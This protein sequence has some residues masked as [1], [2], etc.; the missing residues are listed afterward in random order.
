MGAVTSDR[1]R[2]AAER[3]QPRRVDRNIKG[4]LKAP[5]AERAERSA[6][7]RAEEGP[8]RPRSLDLSGEADLGDPDRPSDKRRGDPPR[9]F[10]R[11]DRSSDILPPRGLQSAEQTKAQQGRAG[12]LL[13][14][15]KSAG[16]ARGQVDRKARRPGKRFRLADPPT[17]RAL[18]ASKLPRLTRGER[19]GQ[20]AAMP[21][22]SQA[23]Y[24]ALSKG[25]RK[26]VDKL[27][28][29]LAQESGP[30]AEVALIA[31]DSLVAGG[32]LGERDA[33]GRTLLETLADRAGK[34]LV[35]SLARSGVSAAAQLGDIVTA[36]AF[37]GT[38]FQ[39][40]NTA[41]CVAASIE[42]VLS[43]TDPAEYA[44]IAT[45]LL[46]DGVTLLKGGGVVELSSSEAGRDDSGRPLA[47]QLIQGSLRDFAARLPDEAPGEG[48][49][50][51]FGSG[52]YGSRRT[53]G[54]GR[55]ASR[56]T[57][58]EGAYPAGGAQAPAGGPPPAGNLVPEAAAGGLTANQAASLYEQ[59]VGVRS[60]PFAVDGANRNA[61]IG[62]LREG[63]GKLGAVS[64]GVRG[65][66]GGGNA[67]YHQVTVVGFAG[68]QVVLQ[69][70]GR[71]ETVQVPLDQFKQDLETITVP[72]G[73]IGQAAQDRDTLPAP[74]GDWF[75]PMM[76]GG[77]KARKRLRKARKRMLRHAAGK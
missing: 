11:A 44:R 27:Y 63:V 1:A 54:T 67:T 3:P 33:T 22:E 65:T 19:E 28:Q 55:Y 57:F 30:A 42:T 77:K 48:P 56:R 4:A 17:A 66:D 71:G 76:K 68:D 24:A 40:R 18:K 25:E 72:A 50:G 13:E 26:Q 52:R 39:G 29:A 20:V 37:P 41:T 64:V 49:P 60:V 9:A 75:V 38:I 10:A 34:P 23:Q 62:M 32:R 36:I 74:A 7:R 46:Y 2:S 6:S 61:A 47:H 8:A 73:F 5:P 51:D 45:G 69:D 58:G 59:A 70:P 53:Y 43:R 35:A 12:E 16:K 15:L 31:L 21:P 14:K